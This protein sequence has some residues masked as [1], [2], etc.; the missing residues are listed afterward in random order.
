MRPARARA[1]NA[2]ALHAPVTVRSNE[3]Q[4]FR[5]FSPTRLGMNHSK[6]D[7]IRWE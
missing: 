4:E 7:Q 2:H 1:A 5:R 3:S 6:I